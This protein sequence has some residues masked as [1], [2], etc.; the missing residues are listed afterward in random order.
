VPDQAPT[1]WLPPE[2]VVIRGGKMSRGPME[3]RANADRP[4]LGYYGLSCCSAP[5]YTRD[6]LARIAGMP[7]SH[8]RASTVERIRNAGAGFDVLPT[9]TRHSSVHATIKLPEP[10]RDADWEALEAAFDE[11]VNNV[12]AL[13]GSD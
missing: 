4:K 3:R 12:A 10:P 11:P 9:P 2:A 8:L 13:E 1:D 7:Q 6:E 5:G